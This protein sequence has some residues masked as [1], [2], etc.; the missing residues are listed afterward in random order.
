MYLNQFSVRIPEGSER[1][2]GY[3]EIGHGQ[4]YTIVLRNARFEA[5]D[6]EVS[7]DGKDIGTFRIYG[8]SNIRLERKPDDNGRFTFYRKGSSEGNKIGLDSIS[9]DDL[10]LIRVKFT[11]EKTDR[12]QSILCFP[13]PYIYYD[14]TRSPI[15]M[16]DNVTTCYSANSAGGTGLSGYSDQGFTSVGSI[17]YDDLQETVIYLRLVAA[18]NDPRPLM[19]VVNTSPVPPPV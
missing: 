15:S 3:V 11:P 7:I 14:G 1:T 5:C 6:A 19:P 8:N 9:Q 16:G 12:T 13:D 2:S 10:G 17:N 18:D 4:Q